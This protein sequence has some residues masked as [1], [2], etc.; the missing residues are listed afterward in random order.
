MRLSLPVAVGFGFSCAVLPAMA[1]SGAPPVA[2]I[3][4][5]LALIAIVVAL[6][7]LPTIVANS[8]GHISTAGILVLNVLLGWTVL[9]W[10]FALV[11]ACS[12]KD[13]AAEA[14]RQRYAQMLAARSAAAGAAPKTCPFCAE[15]VKATAIKCK[16]CGSDLR[17]S[18]PTLNTPA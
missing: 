8:R 10:I 3:V 18:P 16:H 13:N 17:S 14:S 6:Y 2:G 4:G 7:F 12:G 9:G 5:A 15:T 1:D 11:W